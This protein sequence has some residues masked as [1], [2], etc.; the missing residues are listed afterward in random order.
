MA[1]SRLPY[2]AAE[3]GAILVVALLLLLVLTLLALAAMN[4]SF[5]QERMAGNAR[6]V[7]TAFQAAEAGL[8][9]GEQWL[10]N[11][12]ARP[13][14][15]VGAPCAVYDRAGL[16][17]LTVEAPDLRFLEDTWWTTNGRIFGEESGTPAIPGVARAPDSVIENYAFVPDSL[18]VGAGPPTGRDFYKITARGT[19]GVAA[20]QAVVESTFTR[21]Y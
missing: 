12:T 21:R 15:C 20:A 18:T 9:D 14:P 8:R 2:R 17:D 11:R 6:N 16:P 13:D 19:G 4:M 7:N 1:S 5:N 10:I 3:G